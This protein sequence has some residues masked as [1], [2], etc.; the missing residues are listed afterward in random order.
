MLKEFKEFALRGSVLDLAVGVVIGAAFGAIVTSFVN[1]LVN[2][3]IGVLI[4]DT[5]LADKT[6]SLGGQ[7][8]LN[9]GSFLN[10]V[11]NFL[12]VAFALFLIVKV[13]N[14]FRRAEDP[15]TRPC[16]FCE[17]EISKSATKCPA[18]TSELTAE[19]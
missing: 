5:N 17:T 9:Y 19:A 3:L 6:V 15:V 10:A 12:V 16:P 7:A 8:V 1:D 13:I 4:G 2:P 18:C 14:R 11:I